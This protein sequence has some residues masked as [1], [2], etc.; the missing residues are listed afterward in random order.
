MIKIKVNYSDGSFKKNQAQRAQA[1]I[2]RV[3][4]IQSNHVL[5]VTSG[6]ARYIV[7]SDDVGVFCVVYVYFTYCM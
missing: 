7:T 4:K 6:T 1:Q 2:K 5:Y 3:N